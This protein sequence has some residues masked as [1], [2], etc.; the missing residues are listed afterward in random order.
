MID[1]SA[2]IHPDAEIEDD[3]H[4]GPF[5]VIGANVKIGRGS[6]IY[7]HVVIKGPCRIGKNNKVFQFSSVGEACQ[8]LKYAGE[9]TLLEIGDNNTI[10]EGCTIHRGTV[11]D[12]G[13]TRIGN[14]NLLM[15]YVHV[16]HD[17]IIGNDCILSNNVG[18]AGHV[19]MGDSVLL[20]GYAA[21]HQFCQI[22]SFS[23]VRGMSGL[24]KDLP[25]YVMASGTPAKATG[26]NF[27]GMRR[28]G[29]SPEDINALRNAYKIVYR[30][31]LLIDEALLILDDMAKDAPVIKLFTESIKNSKRGI[32]R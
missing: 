17:C 25:A 10:R 26:M 21:A 27:E 18:L 22:G 2:A 12:Q 14:N 16:A 15:A 13:A 20:G 7:S 11:Q 1:P 24:F 6:R 29:W 19:K 9:P 23:M 28:K 5:S 8:D 3:V 31:G 32:I 30:Q 4:I